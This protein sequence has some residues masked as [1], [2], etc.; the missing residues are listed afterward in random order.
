M[1]G[2]PQSLWTRHFALR[3]T[4]WFGIGIAGLMLLL[5]IIVV[6]DVPLPGWFPQE[7]VLLF[8][9]GAAWAVQAA[10]RSR[11][12][13]WSDTLVAG[14]IATALHFLVYFGPLVILMS[15]P[16]GGPAL[17]ELTGFFGLLFVG[18]TLALGVIFLLINQ[19]APPQKG[20]T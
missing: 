13:R 19:I 14:A 12:A 16:L 7:G 9:A 20:K 10:R 18:Y 3:F 4:V 1:P 6:N 17:V 5:W 11:I 2:A 15:I 8:I